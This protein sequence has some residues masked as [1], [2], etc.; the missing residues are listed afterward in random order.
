MADKKIIPR[1]IVKYQAREELFVNYNQSAISHFNARTSL[2]FSLHSRMLQREKFH[3]LKMA[4]IQTKTSQNSR[5][6]HDSSNLEG[7]EFQTFVFS[8]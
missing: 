5:L 3:D 2:R 6:L 4:V 8:A 7:H 1:I